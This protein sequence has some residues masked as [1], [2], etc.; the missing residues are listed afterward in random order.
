MEQPQLKHLVNKEMHPGEL[1]MALSKCGIHMMP[2]DD[3]AARAGIK[4]KEKA[5]E[6]R[7]I[8]DISQCLKAFAF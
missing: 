4:L 5:A 2:E 3:D 7:A 1:L 8:I 6:E